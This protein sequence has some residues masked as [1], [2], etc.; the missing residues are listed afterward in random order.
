MRLI[1]EKSQQGRRG[2]HS[3]SCD[4]EKSPLPDNLLRE[5]ECQFPELS[6]LDVVRHFTTLSQRNFSIDTQFYPLGSCTMKYN[7]K[8]TEAIAQIP[9]F[10]KLHPMLPQLKGG[11]FLVQGAL[12]VLYEMEQLLKEITGLDAFTMQPLAGAHGELTGVMMMAAY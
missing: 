10:S 3:P 5:K 8:F 6:E 1:F 12:Q 4:V 11:E 9:G 2:Y 7:P